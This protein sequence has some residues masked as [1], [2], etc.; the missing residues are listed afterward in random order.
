VE[1]GLFAVGTYAVL[2]LLWGAL[3]FIYLGQRRA[4][5]KS[6]P[7]VASLLAVMMLDAVKNLFE[8]VFFGVLWGSRFNVFPVSWGAPLED[9]WVMP[10]P[11]VVSAFVACVWLWRVAG[12]FIPDQLREREARRAAEVLAAQARDSTLQQVRES[13]RQLQSL[14]VATT[15]LVSFWDIDSSGVFRLK[16]YNPAARIFFQVDESVVGQSATALL[17]NKYNLLLEEALRTKRPVHREA[18]R[19]PSARGERLVSIQLMP[20]ADA[21]GAVV[22]IASVAHD[23]SDV[24]RRAEEQEERQRLESLGLLAG[25]V[26]HDFNNLL[27]VVKADVDLARER[28]G[29]LEDGALAHAGDAIARAR[30]LVEQLMSTAGRRAQK[31][32]AVDVGNVVADT[33]R[34]LAPAWPQVALRVTHS[35]GGAYVVGDRPQLQQIVLNLLQNG[36]EAASANASREASVSASVDVDGDHVV[37]VV[38]DSGAGIAPDARARIFDPFFTTKKSGRGLGLATVF[39]LA[40][41]HGGHVRVDDVEGAGARFTVRL[42]RSAEAPR[43]KTPSPE[44]SGPKARPTS[45]PP[46]LTPPTPPQESPPAPI[47]PVRLRILLVDD[48]DLVRRSTRRQLE[49]LGHTVVDVNGGHAALAVDAPYDVAVIDVTMPDLDGPATLQRLRKK[50]PDLAAVIVTG[51]GDVVVDNDVVLQKPFDPTLMRGALARALHLRA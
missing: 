6:D 8:S 15:D 21:N 18:W 25:G 19:A 40:Q 7:L 31:K 33:V 20:I 26:A 42:P 23:I 14:F 37:V 44:L 32:E 24:T 17:G 49:H 47:D 34:L 3:V 38:T 41:A 43:V 29:G 27:A 5:Q 11:K 2:V 48:D 28:D 50:R 13:E 12:R 10:L 9:P 36:A 45:T 22:Q 35:A 51:R 46:T 16:G 39:G 1:S 4:A 30:E